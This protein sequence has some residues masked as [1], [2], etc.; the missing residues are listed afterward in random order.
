MLLQ[1]QY[2][3][4]EKNERG[5][6]YICVTVTTLRATQNMVI[7]LRLKSSNLESVEIWVAQVSEDSVDDEEKNVRG[8]AQRYRQRNGEAGRVETAPTLLGEYR[9]RW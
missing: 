7:L 6:H 9:A 4:P 3:V 1:Y 5:M 8:S 2:H